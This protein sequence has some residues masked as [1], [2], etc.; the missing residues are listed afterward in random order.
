MNK[1]LL[2]GTLAAT[3]TVALAQQSTTLSAR[4]VYA[5]AKTHTLNVLDLNS[6]SSIATFS[7][8]GKITYAISSDSRQFVFAAHRDDNRV[9]VLH[10]GLSLQDHGD[11]KD[12]VEKAPHVLATMNVG[13]Q[14]THFFAHGKT[15]AF[16]NDGDG[17]VAILDE[18]KLGLSLDF[19][20]IKSAQP[21]HAGLVVLEDRVLVGYLRL[22]RVDVFERGSGQLLQSLPGCPSLHGETMH[23]S[24]YY[25]G[26]GDGV[27][28]V[29]R[30]GATF[31]ATKINNPTS[32]PENTRVGT[33]VSH[34][35]L[36]FAIGNFGKGLA[37]VTPGKPTLETMALS[38]APVK[39]EFADSGA[40]VVLTADGQLHT[41]EATKRSVT[42]SLA[43]TPAVTT[44][45]EGAV[46]PGF[47]LLRDKAYVT[48]LTTGEILEVN[49]NGMKLER[50]FKVGGAPASVTMTMAEGVKH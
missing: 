32:T 26:C 9:T 38:A 5:D 6:G 19:E 45:G 20:Q 37:F 14:P 30:E 33:L 48:S 8:P 25:W 2:F 27:L 24:G 16:F 50:R 12:L 39:M 46:R 17:T 41:L 13:K 40:L 47:A 35:K 22:G 28:I 10:S 7:T 29:K 42:A 44:S 18:D 43:V 3:L 15:V 23:S 11:H 36:G 49:L 21:D 4:L 34:D 31:T 1:A